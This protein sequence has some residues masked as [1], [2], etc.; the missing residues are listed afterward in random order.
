MIFLHFYL[1]K[2]KLLRIF[3][4]RHQRRA[5]PLKA[6]PHYVFRARMLRTLQYEAEN[7]Y[8]VIPF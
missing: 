4:L 8:I 7:W 3:A 1:H 5:P 6:D 2:I